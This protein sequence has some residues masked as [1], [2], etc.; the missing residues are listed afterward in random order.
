MMYNADKKQ[1]F[2][3]FY[4][5]FSK[6]MN[7]SKILYH[8]ILSLVPMYP[9]ECGGII[10]GKNNIVSHFCIDENKQT[11]ISEYSPN[12][13]FINETITLWQKKGIDF[14]GIFHTHPEYGRIL[15]QNDKKYITKIMLHL[16]QENIEL[17]FPIIIPRKEI[18]PYY[19]KIVNGKVFIHEGQINFV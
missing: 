14:L 19:S 7:I 6:F 12:I 15:S 4:G 2:L 16:N 17:L 18:I 8:Q 1:S 11:S 10:A 9:P 3:P 13:N 5:D